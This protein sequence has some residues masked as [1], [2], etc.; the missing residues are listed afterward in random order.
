[1]Q[2]RASHSARRHTERMRLAVEKSGCQNVQQR[3]FSSRPEACKVCSDLSG[4]KDWANLRNENKF[5]T[6]NH[7]HL[8]SALFASLKERPQPQAATEAAL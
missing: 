8:L 3:E 5:A 6:P 2:T 1:M 7:C 4:E